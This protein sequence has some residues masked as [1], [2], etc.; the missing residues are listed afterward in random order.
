MPLLP[1]YT[2]TRMKRDPV[3][4][5]IFGASLAALS[6]LGIFIVGDEWGIWPNSVKGEDR[7]V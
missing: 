4:M 6:G 3:G 2:A 5:Y 1:A 7:D